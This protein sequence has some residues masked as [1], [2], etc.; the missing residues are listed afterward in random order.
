M[1]L[2]VL[3]LVVHYFSQH[4]GHSYVLLQVART[5]NKMEYS[6]GGSIIITNPRQRQY[7]ITEVRVEATR[8]DNTKLSVSPR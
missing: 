2:F 7:S 1:S 3:S 8:S 4:H 5:Q 6:I